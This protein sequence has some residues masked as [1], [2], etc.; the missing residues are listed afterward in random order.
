MMSSCPFTFVVPK[1]CLKIPGGQ[2]ESAIKS[3][4]LSASAGLELSSLFN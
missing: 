1:V 2:I 4:L 3:V